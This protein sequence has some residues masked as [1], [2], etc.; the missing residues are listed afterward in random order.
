MPHCTS[1]ASYQQ[2]VRQADGDRPRNRRLN[3]RPALCSKIES[4]RAMGSETHEGATTLETRTA[5][6]RARTHARTRARHACTDYAR[7]H[8]APRRGALRGLCQAR[9]Q[10]AW[11]SCHAAGCIGSLGGAHPRLHRIARSSGGLKRRRALEVFPTLSLSTPP[12]QT[13]R[14]VCDD[15]LCLLFTTLQ[16]A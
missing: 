14:S 13:H 1:P 4:S 12:T 2:P 15:L 9:R 5:R 16:C 6:W 7:T 3:L 10:R 11:H 8:T